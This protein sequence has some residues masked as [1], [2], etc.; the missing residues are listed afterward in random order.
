MY[1]IKGKTLETT[2]APEIS[3]NFKFHVQIWQFLLKISPFWILAATTISQN[4]ADY[5]F[6]MLEQTYLPIMDD[7]KG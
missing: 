7:I 6:L 2:L 5:C 1:D 4:T 3:C